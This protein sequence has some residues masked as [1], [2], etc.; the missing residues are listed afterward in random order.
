[1][2]P[3]PPRD[4]PRR[5]WLGAEPFPALAVLSF[6]NLFRE[7]NVRIEDVRHSAY[8]IRF[9]LRRDRQTA[10]LD[11]HYNGRNRISRILA[12]P[13]SD[14]GLASDLLVKTAALQ[15]RPFAPAPTET[16]PGLPAQPTPPPDS[17]PLP[18]GVPHPAIGRFDAALRRRLPD[19]AAAVT[20][21]EILNAYQIRYRFR[22]AAGDEAAILYF[23]NARGVATGAAVDGRR[24][25][26]AAL[27]GK[28]LALNASKD[29]PA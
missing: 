10:I 24:T 4:W 16:A 12:A 28:V 1:M 19:I 11:V 26:S 17:V 20:G 18:D 8:L 2:D 5:D 13:N 25:T 22:N 9:W 3:I 15:G 6:A 29:V 23:F 14:T 21:I 7:N 27:A